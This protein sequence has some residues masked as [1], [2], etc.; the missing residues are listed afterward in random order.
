MSGSGVAERQLALMPERAR[1]DRLAAE[2]DRR[3]PEVMARIVE[4]SRRRLVAGRDHW[5]MKAAFE[6]ARYELALMPDPR[7]EGE[8]FRLN[9][10]HTAW[11]A[12]EVME[13][14]P[15]LDGMF[16]TKPRRGL[17]A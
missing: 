12:R 6:V 14:C 7:G 10:N 15:D 4:L 13:R 5:S 17:G 11:Y 9:N 8:P 3:H 16:A 1:L 2:F